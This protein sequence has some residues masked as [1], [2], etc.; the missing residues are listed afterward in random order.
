MHGVVEQEAKE[1]RLRITLLQEVLEAMGDV[2][3]TLSRGITFGAR[4][5]RRNTREHGSIKRRLVQWRR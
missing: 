5:Q 3:V 2:L 4:R 1:R